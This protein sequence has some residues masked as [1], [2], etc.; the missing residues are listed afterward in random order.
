MWARTA[1]A[2]Y[3]LA[4]PIVFLLAVTWEFVFEDIIEPLLI[5]DYRLESSVDR[6]ESVFVVIALVALALIAPTIALARGRA[7]HETAEQALRDSE[8]RFR[9]FVEVSSDWVWEMD[10]TLRFTYVSYDAEGEVDKALPRDA[11]G[12]TRWE[13]TGY[14]PETDEDWRQHKELLEAH[15]P[16]R[17]FRFS[18]RNNS[19][20]E[21]FRRVSG[22]PIFDSEGTFRGYRGTST[23][24]TEE[25]MTRRQARQAERR[26]LEA[27]D[28]VPDWLALWDADDRLVFSNRQY[29]DVIEPIAPGRLKPGITFEELL[30]H[31]SASGEFDRESDDREAFIAKR[32]RQHRNPPSFATMRRADGSWLQISELASADGG[33]VMIGSDIS[34]R[35]HAEADLRAAK[36]GAEYADRAKSEFLANMSHELRTP[37]NAIIGFAQMITHQVFGPVEEPRYVDYIDSIH[38]SGEHLLA[39]IND[40]LDISKIEAGR[41]DLDESEVDVA[42][43]IEDCLQLVSVRLTEGGL[44]VQREID[45]SLPLCRADARMLKQM[46]LNLLSNAV[47][48]TDV[49]GLVT[50]SA[51][52]GQ[53][54]WLAIRVTDNGIGIAESDLPTALA[55]FGQVDS[56][57][58]RQHQGT[59]LGL[60]LVRSLAELHGG[61]LELESR[62]GVGT[63]ATIRLPSERQIGV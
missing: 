63:E 23:D 51:A 39:L 48:F 60:P 45:S 54:G 24:E 14:D 7:L 8:E 16:F 18:M 52:L 61:S 9:D 59:G 10:E 17:N 32:L 12:L 25:V 4:L 1:L 49:G 35:K 47:K 26:F 36:E 6:W 19:G 27:I 38:Q 50:V 33:T 34:A 55:T 22:K 62:P 37:L 3:G 43:L 13:A 2:V 30:H 21:R 58:S 44:S 41:A 56:V 53:D 28:N 15:E 11:V 20:E 42:Q 40:V 46:L 31:V 5:D 29:L 57:L